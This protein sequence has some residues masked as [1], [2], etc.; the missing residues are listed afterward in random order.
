[1]SGWVGKWV[2]GWVGELVSEFRGNTTTRSEIKPYSCKEFKMNQ[3]VRI[4]H[5][6]LKFPFKLIWL[7][8]K[9]RVLQHENIDK[10]VLRP[11]QNY[12]PG[13][14]HKLFT[15]NHIAIWIN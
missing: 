5:H 13:T 2:S 8:D 1:M 7:P 12:K 3:V 6:R 11:N 4:H 14:G 10:H 15:V 9:I